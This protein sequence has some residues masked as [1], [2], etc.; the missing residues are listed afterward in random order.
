MEREIARTIAKSLTQLM[1]PGG[2][3]ADQLRDL[4]ERLADVMIEVIRDR[5]GQPLFPQPGESLA[6]SVMTPKIAAL[7][8]DRVYRIPILKPETVPEEIGFYCATPPEMGL[9]AAGLATLAAKE[10]AEQAGIDL[11][12]AP[13]GP[14]NAA[15]EAKN[16]RFL[17]SQ[18][19]RD[20]GVVPTLFYHAQGACRRE[21]PPGSRQV[22]AA[23]ISEIAMVDESQLSWSQVLEFRRDTEARTKYRRV[24]RWIDDE[25]GAASPE[26]VLDLIALRLDDYTWALKKHGIKTLLGVLSCLLDPKFLGTSSAAVATTGLM[27]GGAWAALAATS[28]AVGRAVLSFGTTYIDSLDERRRDNYEIAYIHEVRKTFA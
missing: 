10:A 26:K 14:G 1:A 27:A 23:A 13:S 22:L 21:F 16:L 25:L 2:S 28:L 6:V 5:L 8:F 17:C 3:P 20:L 15:E 11:G 9:W 19:S 18:F 7:A 12:A 4:E 24:V